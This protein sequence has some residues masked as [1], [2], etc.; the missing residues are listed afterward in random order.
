[1]TTPNASL[2]LPL[3]VLALL[4]S[5]VAFPAAAAEPSAADDA[6]IKK[7]VDELV[8]ANHIL[9]DQAVLDGYGHVSARHPTRPTHYL[10]ARSMAPALVTADDIIEH[11]E[12]GNGV[13]ARG[14]KLYLERSIHTEIYRSRPDVNAVVHSHS[15]AVIPFGVSTVGLRPVFH[16]AGFLGT[17]VPVY[18]IRAAGGMTDMLVTTPAL[19][20][21]LA[22]SLGEKPVAL[23]RGHGDVVVGSTVQLAVY[24][25]YFTEVN[26]RLQ[27]QAL[28]LGKV[29]YLDAE[30][31]KKAETSINTTIGRPWELWVR[32]VSA[33]K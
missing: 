30:E 11:D 7:A 16:M 6:A 32:R 21:A 33:E 29:T 23:M 20:K 10:L 2:R 5:I 17:R 12:E 31:A 19:G 9:A 14:R 25:A 24:R 18:D 15:P 22:V 8:L 26:A 27:Q 4:A 3:A 13:D 28:A 1:M